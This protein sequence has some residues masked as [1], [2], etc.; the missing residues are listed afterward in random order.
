MH[1]HLKTQLKISP[2]GNIISDTQKESETLQWFCFSHV[3]RKANGVA[4]KCTNYRLMGFC[5]WDM[6]VSEQISLLNSCYDWLQLVMSCVLYRW[7]GIGLIV[8]LTLAVPNYST[9][10]VFQFPLESC[11]SYL[12]LNI[13]FL[14]C[15]F[16]IKY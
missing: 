7:K 13:E 6:Y 2:Y 10:L 5:Q 3:N 16:L 11:S 12:D 8:S 4:H 14:F 1:Q 15:S 9:P